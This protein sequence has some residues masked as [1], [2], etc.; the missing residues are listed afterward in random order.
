[1]IKF[2]ADRG[3]TPVQILDDVIENGVNVGDTMFLSAV[4]DKDFAV[5]NVLV[6]TEGEEIFP[7]GYTEEDAEKEFL[8]LWSTVVKIGV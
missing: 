7:K 5:W 8:T 4:V 2:A 6:Y 3:K 1:M